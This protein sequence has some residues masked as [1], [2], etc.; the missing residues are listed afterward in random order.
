MRKMD[1]TVS[2]DE[3]REFRNLEYQSQTYKS[4]NKVGLGGIEESKRISPKK[5]E[6]RSPEKKH[7]PLFD[8]FEK[9]IYLRNIT[10]EGKAQEEETQKRGGIG[11]VHRSG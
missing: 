4:P 7:C 2:D 6:R 11:Q 3:F 10:E 1:R 8:E 5:K 9:E